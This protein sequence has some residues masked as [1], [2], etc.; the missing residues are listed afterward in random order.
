[1]T[2]RLRAADPYRDAT[3]D[4]ASPEARRLFNDIVAT[5]RQTRELRGAHARR[6]PRVWAGVAA[7]AAA[8]AILVV[9]ATT[10]P[11]HHTEALGPAGYR[12]T[13]QP[14]GAVQVIV[15]WSAVRDPAAIQAALDRA[16]AHTK[17]WVTDRD[18]TALWCRGPVDPFTG[19]LDANAVEYDA[20]DS[21]KGLLIRPEKFPAGVTLLVTV[22]LSGAGSTDNPG[23][24]SA[25][26]VTA[27]YTTAWVTGSTADCV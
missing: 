2:T 14:D 20:P 7:I 4:P 26:P 23:T 25:Q 17:I 22:H 11:R 13:T 6:R 16:H 19:S 1:M 12:V 10:S 9:S 18:L 8:T 3:F 5:P 21:A 24:S 27:G 15:R